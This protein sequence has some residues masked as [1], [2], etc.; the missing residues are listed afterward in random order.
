[1]TSLAL[2][3][4]IWERDITSENHGT[5]VHLHIIVHTHNLLSAFTFFSTFYL[6]RSSFVNDKAGGIENSSVL[7]GSKVICCVQVHVKR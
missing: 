1:M 2:F 4:V 3:I 5:P 7:V 6:L